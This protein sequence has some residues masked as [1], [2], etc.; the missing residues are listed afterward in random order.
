MIASPGVGLSGF[1]VLCTEMGSAALLRTPRHSALKSARAWGM[2]QREVGFRIERALAEKSRPCDVHHCPC[3]SLRMDGW[4]AF[5]T[6]WINVFD[7]GSPAGESGACAAVDHLDQESP[8]FRLM[9]LLGGS[10]HGAL[11][12]SDIGWL[13]WAQLWAALAGIVGCEA[14]HGNFP[15]WMLRR[16]AS[17]CEVTRWPCP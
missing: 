9:S 13:A 14:W 8:S 5:V 17:I 2:P 1:D 6:R 3:A 4:M 16:E 15:R 7:R 11:A 12:A 10:M